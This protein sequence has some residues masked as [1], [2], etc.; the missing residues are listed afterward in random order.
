MESGTTP[1]DGGLVKLSENGKTDLLFGKKW[2][3]EERAEAVDEMSPQL[4]QTLVRHM[5]SATEFPAR[6]G[7][8]CQWCDFK[9]PCGQ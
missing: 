2:T 5:L 9:T 4:V 8:R 1:Y 3:E 6:P 7:P